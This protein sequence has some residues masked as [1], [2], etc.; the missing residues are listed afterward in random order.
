MF[1]RTPRGQNLVLSPLSWITFN[2][3]VTLFMAMKL[4]MRNRDPLNTDTANMITFK[5]NYMYTITLIKY[6]YIYNTYWRER[7]ISIILVMIDQHL[8]HDFKYPEVFC[9]FHSIH[10][11]IEC[12]AQC[13]S[14]EIINSQSSDVIESCD[15]DNDCCYCVTRLTQE[16]A[17]WYNR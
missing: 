1:C 14:C 13:G 15:F 17:I 3:N 8:Q 12:H 9:C 10:T 16:R 4:Y 11:A 6:H 7:S 2:H 5:C